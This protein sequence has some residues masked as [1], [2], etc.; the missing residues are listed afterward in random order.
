MNSSELRLKRNMEFLK[1]KILVAYASRFGTTEK[2]AVMLADILS[3]KG[4]EVELID[5]KR[6]EHVKPDNYDLIIIGGSFVASKMNTFVEKFVKR[7]LNI[8]LS[9]KTGIFMC[10]AVE[11]WENEIK[12]GFPAELLDKAIA[13]GYFGYEMNW[14]RWNF[15]IRNM[16]KKTSNITETVSKINTENIKKFAEEITA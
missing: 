1:M 12:K 11:D 15:R 7:N 10:G 6:D 16:M 9:K 2:C 4:N 13:K 3:R 14:D 5:L 8:L